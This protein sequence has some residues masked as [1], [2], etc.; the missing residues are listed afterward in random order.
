[1][2]IEEWGA[3]PWPDPSAYG[4][5][6]PQFLAERPHDHDVDCGEDYCLWPNTGDEY[7]SESDGS[8]AD[9]WS[10]IDTDDDWSDIDIDIEE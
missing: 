1:M 5:R 9:D 6:D 7:D 8:D 3:W 2:K 10:D 4:L